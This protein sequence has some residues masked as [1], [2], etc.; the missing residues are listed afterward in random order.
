ML[1]LKS[2]SLNAIIRSINRKEELDMLLKELSKSQSNVSPELVERAQ[3]AAEPTPTGIEMVS[4]FDRSA[5]NSEAS[6]A[7]CARTGLQILLN[8]KRR[9]SS[10]ATP[11]PLGHSEDPSGSAPLV[12]TLRPAE[13]SGCPLPRRCPRRPVW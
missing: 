11:L 4:S 8:N 13:Q 12:R 6:F 10:M 7:E 9:K 3:R 2:T 5:P 1:G